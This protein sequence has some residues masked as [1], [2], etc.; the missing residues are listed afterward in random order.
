M[1][2]MNTDRCLNNCHCVL[3]HALF[4]RWNIDFDGAMVNGTAANIKDIVWDDNDEIVL[5]MNYRCIFPT[6]ERSVRTT[7]PKYIELSQRDRSACASN[8]S[9]SSGSARQRLCL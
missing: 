1:M 4:F 8:N 2:T 6:L 7:L 3:A 9:F 5:P